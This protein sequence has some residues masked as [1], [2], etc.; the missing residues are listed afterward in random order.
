MAYIAVKSKRIKKLFHLYKCL[1]FI[2]IGVSL[3][4]FISFFVCIALQRLILLITFG[5]LYI[6]GALITAISVKRTN[7]LASGIEGERKLTKV[8]SGLD[9]R[10][11]CF[12]N[13]CVSYKGRKSELD[14]VVVGPTGIFVVEAKNIKG[15]VSGDYNEERWRQ[16]KTGRSGKMYSREF[17]NPVKQIST[18]IYRLAGFLKS[19][20]FR[21]RIDGMVYFTNPETRISISGRDDRINILSE[22]YNGSKMIVNHIVDAPDVLD[23]EVLVRIVLLLDGKLSA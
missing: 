16:R 9:N 12:K 11:C 19:H 13:L 4:S 1:S 17:Y 14:M 21:V 22:L 5:A 2:G 15:S 18:H 23:E 7:T 20:G 8:V 10:Y 3:F 6:C